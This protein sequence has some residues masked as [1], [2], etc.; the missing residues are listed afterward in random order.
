MSVTTECP[1]AT[2]YFR[3]GSSDKVYHATIEPSVPGFTVKFAYGRR[4]STLQTGTKTPAPV[5]Y[6]EAVVIYDRLIR[7]KTAKGYSPAEIGTPYQQT[8]KADRATGVRPQLLN[9][10]DEAEAEMLITDPRW[11]MQEKVDGKR[12]LIRRTGDTVIGINRMG[13]VI[14]LPQTVVQCA[15]KIPSMQFIIDG[16]CI[17]DTFIAFDL[18]EKACVN[19]RAEPYRKRLDALYRTPV[20]GSTQPMQFIRT[21]TKTNEKRTLL[22]ELRRLNKEGVVFKRID[23]PYTAGR[24]NSGGDQLKLKFIATASCIVA[25]TNGSKRSIKLELISDNVRVGVGNVTIPPN[26]A[27][28][29]AGQVV[30]VRYL[31]AYPGG[32]LFQ[33]VYLGLRDDLCAAECKVTQL[34]F[35]P[36]DGEA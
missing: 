18:L 6:D 31:Y 10:I 36:E 2:L 5:G 15:L 20:I 16:E 25:G 14:A 12:V 11:L 35:K 17:G 29:P 1:Q 33:P 32:S 8:P 3:Q 24:P 30:E 26:Q 23:A 4:G 28:P 34:K 7:E 13:L 22:A 9:P 27:I 19:L 21:A